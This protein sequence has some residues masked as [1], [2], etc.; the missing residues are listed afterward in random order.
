[1]DYEEIKKAQQEREEK[2]KAEMTVLTADLE[3]ILTDPPPEKSAMDRHAELLDCMLYAFMR[4]NLNE[5]K[6]NGFFE[7]RHLE[8]A[9]R[10]QKQCLDTLKAKATV[11]Y[12]QAI[13]S[14]RS[15]V[16]PPSLPPALPHPLIHDERTD[17]ET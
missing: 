6:Q 8:F 12:M 17:K 4:R 13:A 10:I 11:G 9:L 15:G 2:A 1:M 14:Y 3:R 16:Y 7:S 5:D